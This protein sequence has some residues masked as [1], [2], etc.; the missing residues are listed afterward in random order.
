MSR[1]FLSIKI[2][3]ILFW[4]IVL[5][6]SVLAKNVTISGRVINPEGNPLKK[7]NVTIKNLKDEIFMETITNRKGQFKFESVKPRFYYIVASDLGYGSK[8]I[9]V[10]P[11]KNK[12]SDLDFIFKLNG[13]DQPV[14]FYLY[15]SSR[16][17]L[18]DPILRI[19]KINI[20]STAETI[21][22]SW[23]DI[24]QAKLYTL[25]ENGEKIYSG[26]EARFEKKV[27]PGIEYCYTLK[28]SSDFGVEG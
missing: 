24:N 16:P 20:K 15:N 21:S 4:P 18:T 1:H 11:R 17:T 25:Y 3:I 27:T 10:N 14:E 6:S 22:L 26:E 2:L 5:S 19:K 12:N 7:V 28:A 9:K 8:R 23:K 13:K